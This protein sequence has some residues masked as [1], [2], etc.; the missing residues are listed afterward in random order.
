M[1]S[2]GSV[3]EKL[4]QLGGYRSQADPLD[5]LMGHDFGELE[6]GRKQGVATDAVLLR[7]LHNLSRFDGGAGG[8]RA[9]GVKVAPLT[10]RIGGGGKQALVKLIRKG[11]TQT[12][13]GLRDQ[14]KY[15]SRDGEE[16][17][18]RSE[19]FFGVE[20]G[21]E[22]QESLVASWGLNQPNETGVDK[23]SHF[24]VSFPPGTDRSAAERA[25]RSWAEEL[26]DSGNFGDVYDYYTV[27]HN[28]TAHPHT[29]VVINRRGV[30]NG[31]WLKISKRGPIDYEVIRHVQVEVAGREGIHLS[32]TPR[33]ARGEA[34]RP[35]TDVEIKRASREARDPLRPEHTEETATKAAV[36]VLS[37][38][39]QI[40]K[41]A[42]EIHEQLPKIAK[43]MKR[44]ALGLKQ[45]VTT[46]EMLQSQSVL[47]VG[48]AEHMG[49]LLSQSRADVT[50]SFA[51]LDKEVQTLRENSIQRINIERQISDNKA[52]AGLFI[53]QFRDLK[54]E[55]EKDGR[56]KGISA[57]DEVGQNIKTAAE[58]R[59][60][61]LAQR[62]GLDPEKTLARYGGSSAVTIN[63]ASQWQTEEIAEATKSGIDAS[64]VIAI[65][66]A[67]KV[68][69]SDARDKLRA[70]DDNKRLIVH[71]IKQV[72]DNRSDRISGEDANDSI[73][74]VRLAITPLQLQGLER[75]DPSQ[76]S[77]ISSDPTTQRVI[78]REYL[79][80]A[81]QE[82]TAEHRA[83]LESARAA[84]D[85]QLE[86]ARQQQRQREIQSRRGRDSGHSR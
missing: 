17:V 41:E 47:Q 55:A 45:G 79:K 15:L 19:R 83:Q 60:A 29:H 23:T 78:A 21:E 75:G 14:M 67:I 24:V 1:N 49:E 74:R 82:A 33:L 9:G 69:Y 58:E 3:R 36:T 10:A 2:N 48:D 22:D 72:A 80:A 84:V 7:Q 42:T 62:N 56:Y 20:I 39:S 38:A 73:Q 8:G 53:P 34:E 31:N 18:V 30:E 44:V 59:V 77:G 28:D 11:G 65:H 40:S 4:Q 68:I 52:E 81:S 26:F 25:G 86:A 76:L 46:Q 35:H 12:A 63:Q 54:V 32:A 6:I 5:W 66:K 27:H 43:A 50:S 64:Q 71:D 57:T 37:Y 70:H 51:R 13:R 61:E 16:T 85:A